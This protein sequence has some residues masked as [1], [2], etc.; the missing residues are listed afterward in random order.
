MKRV[1][2]VFRRDTYVSKADGTA[3]T[4]VHDEALCD[5]LGQAKEIILHVVGYRVGT[6]AKATLTAFQGSD[7]TNRPFEVGFPLGSPIVV[8]TLRPPASTLTGPFQGRVDLTLQIEED[9]SPSTFAEFDL[10]VYATL[11]LED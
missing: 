7:P 11:I 5:V 9:P 6:E 1:L 4:Y 10:G 8:T 3:Q 2:T